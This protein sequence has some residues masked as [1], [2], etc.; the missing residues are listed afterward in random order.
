MDPND[1]LEYGIDVAAIEKAAGRKAAGWR[2]TVWADDGK[3]GIGAV[4]DFL[5]PF[6]IRSPGMEEA[7]RVVSGFS[8][9]LDMG[10]EESP[11][12]TSQG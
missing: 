1:A 9:C 2:E 3:G 8:I 7:P 6:V 5:K 10:D 4:P 11:G 12:I